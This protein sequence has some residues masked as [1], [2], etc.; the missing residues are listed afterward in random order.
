MS[1][2]VTGKTVR[3]V[4]W[5]CRKT[6][7]L[8]ACQSTRALRHRLS[9]GWVVHRTHLNRSDFA[10]SLCLSLSLSFS[11][12][13]YVSLSLSLYLF[14][15]LSLSLYLSLSLSPSLSLSL[16]L[17]F[18]LS[19]PW[20]GLWDVSFF[21][22]VCSPKL[23]IV[24][25]EDPLQLNVLQVHFTSMPTRDTFSKLKF[26]Y[27]MLKTAEIERKE[28]LQLVQT[29]A[30]LWASSYVTK[31]AQYACENFHACALTRFQKPQQVSRAWIAERARQSS[32]AQQA[33]PNLSGQRCC[34]LRLKLLLALAKK[35]WK[36]FVEF[37]TAKRLVCK[38][39][40]PLV[41]PPSRVFYTV[42]VSACL[43]VGK[44][45]FQNV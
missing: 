12:S 44:Q 31:N 19:R 41:E 35:T 15:S 3:L 9:P 37:V 43:F 20:H 11:L 17:S 6:R 21:A 30:H 28:L 27:D 1:A 33:G 2:A 16:S 23:S 32:R 29:F 8:Q 45:F 10:L 42:S 25:P 13:L 36:L 26:S 39:G 7:V 34:K 24:Y 18:S 40:H 4:C 5:S 22:P 38:N 14:L